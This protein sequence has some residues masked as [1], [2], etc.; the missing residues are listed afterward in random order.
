M[1]SDP[2]KDESYIEKTVERRKIT[3]VLEKLNFLDR[4]F[5][6]RDQIMNDLGLSRD[7]LVGEAVRYALLHGKNTNFVELEAPID[8]I[9]NNIDVVI[10]TSNEEE[11]QDPEVRKALGMFVDKALEVTTDAIIETHSIISELPEVANLYQTI[12][13]TYGNDF[14]LVLK[15]VKT[16][17]DLGLTKVTLEIEREIPISI[18][19]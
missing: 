1:S 14:D 2:F 4:D 19:E 13:N 15:D 7:R 12:R 11:E 6:A 5:T 9:E 17:N 10:T 16:E 8:E 18:I 3:V